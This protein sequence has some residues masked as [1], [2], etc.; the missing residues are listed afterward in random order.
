MLK[1]YSTK[2]LRSCINIPTQ[3]YILSITCR[4][5]IQRLDRRITFKT[6]NFHAKDSQISEDVKPDAGAVTVGQKG[7]S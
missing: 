7:M 5:N 2:T 1:L 4:P 6:G 3:R